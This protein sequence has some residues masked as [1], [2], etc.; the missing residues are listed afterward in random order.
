MSLGFSKLP[1]MRLPWFS[2]K[3][4]KSKE[5]KFFKDIHLLYFV[6]LRANRL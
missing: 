2:D 5:A 6:N 3:F 4:V 1:E